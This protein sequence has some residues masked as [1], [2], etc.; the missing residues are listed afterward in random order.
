MIGSTFDV[1]SAGVDTHNRQS[2]ISVAAV[3]N[4]ECAHSCGILIKESALLVVVSLIIIIQQWYLYFCH[5]WR[6]A[7]CKSSYR[8][9]YVKVGQLQVAANLTLSQLVSSYRPNIQPLPF[10][11]LL[12]HNADTHFTIPQRVEGWVDLGTRAQ[13]AYLRDFLEK[14]K[15]NLSRERVRS[16]DQHVILTLC[17]LTMAINVSH[18]SALNSLKAFQQI[19]YVFL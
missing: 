2:S 10:V 12:G 4:E 8:V 3:R 11:L 9:T 19:P 16:R 6:K 14:E 15:Q 1:K 18:S 13:S 7:I 5:L 17:Q